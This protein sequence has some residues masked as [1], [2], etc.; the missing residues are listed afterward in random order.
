MPV[1]RKKPANF[2]SIQQIETVFVVFLH[3]IEIIVAPVLRKGL[4][5]F[6][7]DHEIDQPTVPAMHVADILGKR[8]SVCEPVVSFFIILAEF[9]HV[10]LVNFNPDFMLE[11]SGACGKQQSGIFIRS[12]KVEESSSLN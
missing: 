8:Q 9:R 6:N 10:F 3:L 7:A 11:K 4:R 1:Q 2:Y 5:T 12:E